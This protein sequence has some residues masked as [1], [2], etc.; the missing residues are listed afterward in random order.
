M[1]INRTNN[2][3]SDGQEQDMSV[4]GHIGELRKRVI[5]ILILFL[6][7]MVI[8][9]FTAEYVI[10]YLMNQPVAEQVPWVVIRLTDAFQVYFQFA[11]VVGLVITFPFAL[12]QLWAFISPGLRQ[13]ERQVTLSLIPGSIFLFVLGLAFGYFWLFPFVVQ[14][15]TGIAERIGVEEMYGMVQYFHFMFS[16]VVPFGFLFQ[17]PILILFLTRLG[18]ITPV[19][20]KK[21]RKYAYFG[22]FVIAALI[23][24][25]EI[26]SHLF[27]TLPLIILYEFSVWL[28]N[29]S[30]K[31]MQRRIVL[32]EMRKK[33]EENSVE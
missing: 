2:I 11:I 25:P 19:L 15:M 18:V 31:R 24:P 23:T 12:Y 16:L 27:V 21:I 1:T 29:V 3:R 32:E 5:Y 6:V 20:L 10:R 28:S 33:K 17:L 14:F 7:S 30:Y 9:F 4:I 13:K 22:L 26:L 8:G